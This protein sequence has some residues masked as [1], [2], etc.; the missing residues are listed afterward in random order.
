MI[1]EITLQRLVDGELD[2]AQ[3]RRVLRQAQDAPPSQQAWKKLAVAYAENQLLQRG[4]ARLESAAAGERSTSVADP[5]SRSI[6]AP[7]AAISPS[8]PRRQA[9]AIS[10]AHADFRSLWWPIATAVCLLVAMVTGYQQLDRN[11]RAVITTTSPNP[12][13]ANHRR[14]LDGTSNTANTNN[15]T[16]ELHDFN[17]QSLLAL[18]PDHHLPADQLPHEIR[19]TLQQQIPL[20][21]ARRFTPPQL[22]DL[23]S[24]ASNW[25][26]WFNN[27]MPEGGINDQMRSDFRNAGLLIDQDIDILSGRLEDGRAFMVPYRSVRL[28]AGQ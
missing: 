5:R 8:T 23:T 6:A 19:Q 13:L 17:R 2:D 25:Q 27:V 7:S 12:A 11:Y 3:T 14:L 16:D 22:T 24:N 4:F 18:K 21:D 10:A 15:G 20:Y 9:S 28:S 26:T 1:D